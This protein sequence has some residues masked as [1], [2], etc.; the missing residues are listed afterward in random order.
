M[1]DRRKPGV[2]ILATRSEIELLVHGPPDVDGDLP[3]CRHTWSRAALR[4]C[5]DPAKEIGH[6]LIL[7]L[8]WAGYTDDTQRWA[9][10][11]RVLADIRALL[12]NYTMV[13]IL[14]PY[15]AA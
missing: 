6:Q 1:K 4:G 14:H 3:V 13:E 10:E 15:N 9:L 8:V 2:W 7:S 11:T 5:S 12:P